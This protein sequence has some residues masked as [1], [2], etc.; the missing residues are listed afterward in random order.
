MATRFSLSVG[1]AIEVQ[2]MRLS[3]IAGIGGMLH[4]TPLT[5]AAAF[6]GGC[7]WPPPPSPLPSCQRWAELG[8]HDCAV[9]GNSSAV[10]VVESARQWAARNC[11]F[12]R[13]CKLLAI[14][15][16]LVVAE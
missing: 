2:T 3:R 10:I 5:V 16:V 12:A 6:R 7:Q 1:V 14:I 4:N 8:I 15:V 13:S 11:R 9:D